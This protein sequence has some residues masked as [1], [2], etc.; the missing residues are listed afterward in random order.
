[1]EELIYIVQDLYSLEV[2]LCIDFDEAESVAYDMY[3]PIIAEIDLDEVTVIKYVDESVL[4]DINGF[5]RMWV[6]VYYVS[7]DDDFTVEFNQYIFNLKDLDDVL[8]KKIQESE[9]GNYILEVARNYVYDVI[10]NI[11]K[12]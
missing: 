10:E 4:V 6:D 2:K 3:D 12:V 8:A 5:T 11:V 7:D 1:M 9:L